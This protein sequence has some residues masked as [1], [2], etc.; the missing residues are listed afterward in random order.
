MT[1]VPSYNSEVDI[2]NCG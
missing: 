1:V 2:V